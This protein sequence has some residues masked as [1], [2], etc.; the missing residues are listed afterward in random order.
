MRYMLY[1]G[2]STGLDS[3]NAVRAVL[4][5]WIVYLPSRSRKD[6]AHQLS[7]LGCLAPNGSHIAIATGC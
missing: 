4:L 6:L 3:G 5:G 7:A 1:T 2:V